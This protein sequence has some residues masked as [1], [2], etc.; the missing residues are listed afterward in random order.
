ME[1]LRIEPDYSLRRL[2]PE[3][4]GKLMEGNIIERTVLKCERSRPTQPSKR[5][6]RSRNV[7]KKDIA[8]PHKVELLV[9]EEH[10]DEVCVIETAPH[11][12][13]GPEEP[14]YQPLTDNLKHYI[15]E[16][17]LLN[18][19]PKAIISNI[20][21]LS[22]ESNSRFSVEETR[23]L[24]KH[25]VDNCIR[26]VRNSQTVHRDDVVALDMMAKDPQ[27]NIIH[28]DRNSDQ[29]VLIL[30]SGFQA[31][32]LE[33]F[34]DIVF[35]DTVHGQTNKG[36][37]QLTMLVVTETGKGVPVAFCL[38]NFEKAEHW[39]LLVDKAFRKTSRN[40][41]N[42]TF[43]S[44]DCVKIK[45][46]VKDLRA[47]HLLCWFHMMQSIDRRLSSY[48]PSSRSK[49]DADDTTRVKDWIKYKIRELQR[50]SDR[51]MYLKKVKEFYHWLM[52]NEVVHKAMGVRAYATMPNGDRLSAKQDFK[53]YFDTYWNG[54]SGERACMWAR[55]GRVG[56]NG[57]HVSWHTHDTNNM[58][59]SYFFQQKH[60]LS[61][62]VRTQRV[63]SH[64][65]FLNNTVIPWYIHDR[66]QMLDGIIMSRQQKETHTID[67]MIDWLRHSQERMSIIDNEIGLGTALDPCDADCAYT[68]CLADMS[69]SCPRSRVVPC[70]HLEAASASV[71][72]TFSMIQKACDIIKDNQLLVSNGI[73]VE[74][75]FKCRK[76][77]NFFSAQNGWLK[78]LKDEHHSFCECLVFKNTGM[79]CHL[80]TLGV[81]LDAIV[82]SDESKHLVEAG[83]VK[84]CRPT[85]FQDIENDPSNR[86]ANE[87]D[88]HI[89]TQVCTSNVPFY[90]DYMND[91]RRMLASSDPNTDRAFI[92]AGFDSLIEY[93]STR[94][95]PD[96]PSGWKEMTGKHR[97]QPTDRKHKALFPQRRAHG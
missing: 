4:V 84:T 63:S 31:A 97:R 22:R 95:A 83:V 30:C 69:C 80:L 28:Y 55:F 5:R 56:L 81:G 35:L 14:R 72:V 59:E 51:N 8:C 90:E 52:N 74:G 89:T 41:T 20:L 71:P 86:F 65:Q 87:P 57:N 40:P 64:V 27:N 67:W 13:H 26:R 68:F 93:L 60:F 17:A 58:I 12:G 11:R 43:M 42:S 75:L 44:D 77:A 91:I 16:Q 37:F 92:K 73:A 29:I 36:L 76:I 88:P 82:G 79:C 18:I 21:K 9:F 3:D 7:S 85:S 45:K 94:F 24:T 61:K 15:E 49:R 66:Q 53:M 19:G 34:G 23:L 96:I 62:S 48:L 6:K 47:K 50:V 38:S 46:C 2:A 32:M 39:S 33:K 10:P 70:V 25:K 78:Q 54:V 1:N